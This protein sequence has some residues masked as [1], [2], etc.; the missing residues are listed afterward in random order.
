LESGPLTEGT[1]GTAFLKTL[2]NTYWTSLEVNGVVLGVEGT[3]AELLWT[4][5]QSPV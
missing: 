1:F 4:L 2:L 3:L 5:E